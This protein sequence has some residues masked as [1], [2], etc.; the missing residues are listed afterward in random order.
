[1]RAIQS[2]ISWCGVEKKEGVKMKDALCG[3]A[4]LLVAFGALSVGPAGAADK[5]LD[6]K[7]VDKQKEA[8]L[9]M[10]KKLEHSQK[11]LAGLTKADFETI[12]KNAQAMQVVGYLEEWDRAGLPEYMRQVRYFND[13]NKELIR[14]AG[15]K[16]IGGAT[17]AYTQ[18]TLSCVHCHN[19][20]RDAKKK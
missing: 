3:L 9:W 16:N 18:L 14:Q 13:A 19:V 6:E 10:V 15:N 11:I 5:K 17:L 1:V 8:S 4:C 2:L 7:K 12:K 20:V